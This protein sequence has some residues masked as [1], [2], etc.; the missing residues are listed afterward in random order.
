[1]FELGFY[2]K[3]FIIKNEDIMGYTYIYEFLKC[4]ISYNINYINKLN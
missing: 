3:N 4:K 2:N 1:M